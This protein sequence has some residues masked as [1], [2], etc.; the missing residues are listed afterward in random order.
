MDELAMLIDA[1][2]LLRS[3]PKLAELGKLDK[4]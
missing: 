1:H 3:V 4:N 2:C